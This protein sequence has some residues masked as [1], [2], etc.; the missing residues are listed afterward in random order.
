MESFQSKY[1]S[2]ELKHKEFEK[3]ALKR[4]NNMKHEQTFQNAIKQCVVV[5]LN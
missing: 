4:K 5:S 3:I 1:K 2:L